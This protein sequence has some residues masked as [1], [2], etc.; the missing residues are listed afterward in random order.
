MLNNIDLTILPLCLLL[1]FCFFE[2][3]YQNTS[4]FVHVI[5]ST[6]FSVFGSPDVTLSLMFDILHQNL[7]LI[8]VC[9]VQRKFCG[10][11]QG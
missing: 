10:I 6:P 4:N 2:K 1:S 8:H 7:S 3:I 11:A 5:L 9:N